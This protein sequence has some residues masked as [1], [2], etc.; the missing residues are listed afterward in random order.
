MLHQDLSL[1]E[2]VLFE[3]V[4][5]NI[6]RGS[7]SLISDFYFLGLG[8]TRDPFERTGSSVMWVN[9]GYQQI[10]IPSS[11]D[12][13][14][15]RGSI[16]L[17]FPPELFS[18]LSK[19]LG[20]IKPKMAGTRFDFKILPEGK[21]ELLGTNN[22]IKTIEVTDPY[23]N[24][25]RIHENNEELNFRGGLGII[26]LELHVPMSTSA[27]IGNFYHEY[28]GALPPSQDQTT[29]RVIVGPRQQFIFR[30]V[31]EMK[32]YDGHHV[33]IYVTNFKKTWERLNQNNLLFSNTRFSDHCEKFEDA[34]RFRQL[35]FKDFPLPSSKIPFEL[36]HEVRSIFHPSYMRP[37][38]NRSGTL[39][40]F[41]NQ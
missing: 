26:Y 9:I 15:L 5:L 24:L 40:I 22:P 20:D 10:H 38:V 37:L 6:P 30:E 28:F 7:Q 39:G 1:G 31:E 12:S 18:G 29:C 27:L 34:L 25:L 23:G 32:A 41:C 33:A 3:H 36:E 8:L 14:V 16:G 2:L 35:R 11:S 4:N 19:R 17:V 21:D 13:Q